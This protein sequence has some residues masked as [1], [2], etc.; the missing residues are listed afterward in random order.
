MA[1]INDKINDYAQNILSKSDVN[2]SSA[3][4]ELKF[5]ISIRNAVKTKTD[6]NLN[7]FEKASMEDMG[8]LD[9]LTDTLIKLEIVTN[10]N[11]LLEKLSTLVE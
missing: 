11:D 5:Y 3:L 8:M 10:K 2:D 1:F 6:K 4:G 9:A 7:A